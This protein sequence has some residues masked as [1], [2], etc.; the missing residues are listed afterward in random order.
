MIADFNHFP[1]IIAK[2]E[3]VTQQL[4]SKGTFDV[5]A[6]AKMRAAVKTGFM[7]GAVYS[8][9]FN[10]TN[11]GA[12]GDGGGHLEAPLNGDTEKGHVGWVV[13]GADYSIFVNDG[14]VH[15]A[16]H[17]FMEPA[18]DEVWPSYEAAWMRLEESLRML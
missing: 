14:T 4:V 17:P 1:E 5:E 18:A 2:L 9:T 8:E 3:E 13:A 10:S 11:Y 16:A 15:Q 6:A 7:R 12:G